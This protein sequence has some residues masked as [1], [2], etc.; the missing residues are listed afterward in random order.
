MILV[1]SRRLA[2]ESDAVRARLATEDPGSVIG[3]L[4]V[5][6]QDPA[7]ARALELFVSLYGAEAGNLALT[8]LPTGGVFVAGGIAPRILP[9]LERGPFL[10]S[11]LGKGRMRPVLERFRVSV[12]LEPRVGLLG[13]ARVAFRDKMTF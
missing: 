6:G 8:V 2:K 13:A 3:E 1:V 9:A 12:V 7:C 4:G 5:S 11:F 10:A